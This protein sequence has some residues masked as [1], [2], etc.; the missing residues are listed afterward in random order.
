MGATLTIA[1][2]A[3][4]I[5]AMAEAWLKDKYADISINWQDH[6]A[7]KMLLEQHKKTYE[8]GPG[9]D[10]W[11]VKVARAGSAR[12]VGIG[13]P[14]VVDIPDLTKEAKVTWRWLN[15][16]AA[17][18]LKEV[19]VLHGGTRVFDLIKMRIQEMRSDIMTLLE[20][21]FWG[22]PS[23]SDEKTPYGLDYYLVWN[24][25]KGFTGGHPT[26]YSDVAGLSRTTYPNHCNYSLGSIAAIT[27]DDFVAKLKEAIFLCD[28]K[29]PVPVPDA[30]A[31]GDDWGFY[32]IYDV[33]AEA[34]KI[35][36]DSND[37]LGPDLAFYNGRVL[38]RGRPITPVPALKGKGWTPIYGVNWKDV[39]IA[40]LSGM[41]MTVGPATPLTAGGQ[42]E[43]VVQHTDS[44]CQ[45]VLR[46]S[47]RHFVGKI[48]SIAN[49]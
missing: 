1:K 27:R 9:P 24:G 32:T 43:A 34:E 26:G 22:C 7:A 2:L 49:T 35:L 30:S 25:T 6:V 17:W 8:G 41:D 11:K 28:F 39:E 14:D 29:A 19:I 36:E 44:S 20:T 16:T 42:H 47:R 38:F 23:A 37:N 13:E 48:T 21:A 15:A 5:N 4:T 10:S 3:D 33:V 31:E 12:F 46:K 45:L 18:F 40:V